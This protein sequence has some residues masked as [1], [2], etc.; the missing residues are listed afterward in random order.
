MPRTSRILLVTVAVLSGAVAAIANTHLTERVYD[1]SF[2]RVWAACVQVANE[3]YTIKFSEKDSGA[4]TF[5]QNMS[6]KTNSAGKDVALTV[7]AISSAQTKVVMHPRKEWA[8]RGDV[9][10]EFLDAVETK[11]SH[12]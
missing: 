11:L 7:T 5:K 6:W 12:R 3:N 2:D 1:A 9:N 4:L 8:A 10:K